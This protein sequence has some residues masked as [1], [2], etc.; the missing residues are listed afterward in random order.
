MPA[1][2]VLMAVYNG[3]RHLA[4]AIESVLAQTFGDFELLVVDDGSQDGSR[5]IAERYDDPRVRVLPLTPNGGLSAAL[6]HGLAAA[7]SPLI[8]RQDADDLAEPHRLEQQVARM[9]AHPDLALLGSRGTAI[10]EDGTPTGEVWRPIGAVNIA[11]YSLVDNPFAHTSVMYRTAIVRDEMGGYDARFDPFSQDY[12]LWTRVLLRYP[13]DNLPDRLIRYRVHESSIIGALGTDRRGAA[14]RQRWVAMIHEIVGRHAPALVPE[15][16]LSRDDTDLLCG[17]LL[18]VDAS[19]LSAF[20]ALF[21]RL[22]TAFEERYPGLRHDPD[23]LDTLARQFDALAFRVHPPTRRASGR[24]YAH[25]L[26]H[27]PGLTA[28]L[29]WGRVAAQSLLGTR[30]RVWLGD[31][32][33]RQSTR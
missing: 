19:R 24:V 23:F 27:H 31:L 4:A 33:R 29:S 32:A 22:V 10:R 15:S 17:F 5:T 21:E 13:V 16:A 1:V 26:R 9:R 7:R 11:W 8:A 6:N 25:A 2:S 18:G 28:T 12:A 30:G 14:Y 3:E 20:L